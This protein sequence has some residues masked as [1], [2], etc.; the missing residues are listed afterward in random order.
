MPRSSFDPIENK[1]GQANA[2]WTSR[3]VFVVDS[4]AVVEQAPR[5]SARSRIAGVRRRSSMTAASLRQVRTKDKDYAASFLLAKA[6]ATEPESSSSQVEG[7]GFWIT[8]GPK[9]A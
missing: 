7:S 8:E 1:G 5:P 3:Y 2:L 9:S 4:T 6:N